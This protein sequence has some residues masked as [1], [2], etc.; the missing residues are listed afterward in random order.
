MLLRACYRVISLSI[1]PY[2]PTELLVRHSYLTDGKGINEMNPYTQGTL[3]EPG[4]FPPKFCFEHNRSDTWARRY[5]W[6]DGLGSL[7]DL[8]TELAQLKCMQ[9]IGMVRATASAISLTSMKVGNVSRIFTCTSHKGAGYAG[10]QGIGTRIGAHISGISISPSQTLPIAYNSTSL[11]PG[12]TV[13]NGKDV[14]PSVLSTS[15]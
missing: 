2:F 10:P 5:L 4:V 8:C 12:M 15:S 3:C 13:S 9:I 7:P 14:H 11:K 6:R 1:P